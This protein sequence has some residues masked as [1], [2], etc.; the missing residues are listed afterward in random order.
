MENPLCDE[1]FIVDVI[2]HLSCPYHS[3]FFQIFLN[4]GMGLFKCFQMF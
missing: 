1:F 2:Y 3:F 4:F